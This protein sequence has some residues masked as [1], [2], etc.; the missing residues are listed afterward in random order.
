MSITLDRI[1]IAHVCKLTVAQVSVLTAEL[2]SY[3]S[4]ARHGGRVRLFTPGA[5]RAALMETGRA[6]LI[7]ALDAYASS[8][9]ESA[10]A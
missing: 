2:P 10:D 9:E 4:P 3:R 7:P 8:K 6:A 1:E 5:I